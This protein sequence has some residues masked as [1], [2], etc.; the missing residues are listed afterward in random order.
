MSDRKIGEPKVSADQLRE[1]G[2]SE[3][4]IAQLIEDGDATDEPIAP[5]RPSTLEE[6]DD[7][8]WRMHVLQLKR[9]AFAEQ[10]RRRLKA[11]ES[12]L[13]AW[14]A[15]YGPAIQ[16]LVREAIE[17]AGGKRRSVDLDHCRIGLRK[18]PGRYLVH[19]QN[20]AA[21]VKA[22]IDQGKPVQPCC[23]EALKVVVEKRGGDAVDVLRNGDPDAKITILA[24]PVQKWAEQQVYADPETGE[25]VPHPEP[26]PGVT[27]QPPVETL[28]WSVPDPKGDRD[29]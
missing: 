14:G 7:L 8:I 17:A 23:I 1:V 19:P 10:S 18:L 4:R 12:K 2:V 28:S 20:L 25:R 13:D 22:L 6:V 15:I 3:E 24:T 26:M 27:W 21:E 29:E 11:M 5:W 9:D 16:A